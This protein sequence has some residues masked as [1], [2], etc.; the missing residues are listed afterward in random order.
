[1]ER[2]EDI[3]NNIYYRYSYYHDIGFAYLRTQPTQ[4]EAAAAEGVTRANRR[5]LSSSLISTR[6]GTSTSTTYITV[7]L[8]G[9]AVASRSEKIGG[10]RSRANTEGTAEWEGGGGIVEINA[11]RRD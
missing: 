1:M 5:F 11:R 4:A 10:A 8:D 2:F 3:F 6:M 9:H 7:Y